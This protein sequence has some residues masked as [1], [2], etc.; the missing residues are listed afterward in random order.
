[1]HVR[2]NIV[3]CGT[4][5]TIKVKYINIGII[6]RCHTIFIFVKCANYIEVRNLLSLVVNIDN[7]CIPL[8]YIDFL[9]AFIP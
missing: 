5:A 6:T 7:K 3:K 8:S 4:I 9:K 1:M 2:Q